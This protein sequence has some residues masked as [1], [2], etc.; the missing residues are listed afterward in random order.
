MDE[1]TIRDRAQAMADGLVAGD[2][3]RALADLSPELRRNLGEVLTLLPLPATD[4]TI[5][6]VEATGSGWTAVIRVVGGTDEVAVATRWKD[7]GGAPTVIEVSHLSRAT[8]AA[9]AAG[10]EPE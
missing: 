1:A 4:A 10:P 5:E 3:E 6:S 2:I 7:R 9:E 8:R